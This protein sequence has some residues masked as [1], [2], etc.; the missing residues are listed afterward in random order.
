MTESEFRAIV[1]ANIRMYRSRH[2]WTQAEFAEKLDI[3]I[4]FYSDIETGKRWLSPATMVKCA[5]VLKIE[6]YELFKPAEAST[7]TA[8]SIISKYHSEIISGVAEALEN[9]Y[10]QYQDE[11]S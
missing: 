9:I 3:S 7:P 8:L 1:R 4:S 5:A 6:P 2:H 10:H 11:P